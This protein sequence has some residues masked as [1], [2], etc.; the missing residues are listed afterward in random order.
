MAHELLGD[1]DVYTLPGE[2]RTELMAETVWHEIRCEGERR[3]ELIPVK[4]A[5]HLD[6]KLTGE[7]VP[8]SLL[9]R[10]FIVPGILS[11]VFEFR[12]IDDELEEIFRD[13]DI[14]VSVFC[15]CSSDMQHVEVIHKN[16][17]AAHT[18]ERFGWPASALE[19]QE[20]R[21]V[22]PVIPG[23]LEDELSLAGGESPAGSFGPGRL[24]ES[25]GRILLYKMIIEC[26]TEEEVKC[27]VRGVDLRLRSSGL[28]VQRILHFHGSDVREPLISDIL[29]YSRPDMQ[30]KLSASALGHIHLIRRD[31]ALG[32]D[33]QRSML[34]DDLRIVLQLTQLLRV[35]P[36]EL[37]LVIR[38]DGVCFTL[39]FELFSV[40]VLF[41]RSFEH[42]S[43]SWYNNYGHLYNFLSCTGAAYSGA[44]LFVSIL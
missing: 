24:Y 35:L 29:K 27:L 43:H 23:D 34:I 28:P 37:D 41:H 5:S 32:P 11:Y 42:F 8:E 38:I 36:P 9:I 14:S 44:A 30:Q 20:V 26:V 31:A 4:P 33:G 13:W 15:F 7:R 22:S 25:D 21:I 10:D 3:D 2:L 19:H 1:S 40:F 17:V 6:I 39:V 16:D 12:S 18:F